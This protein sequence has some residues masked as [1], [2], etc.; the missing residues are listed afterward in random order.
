MKPAKLHEKLFLNRF[1]PDDRSHLAIKDRDVCLKCEGKWCTY[2][3]PAA[4]YHW[5]EE[6]AKIDITYEACLEC[7]TCRIGCPYRNIEWVYP[8]G[9]FGVQHRFG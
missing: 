8:R 3:C 2:F 9:G 7:G 4:V 6:D 5:N 1:K